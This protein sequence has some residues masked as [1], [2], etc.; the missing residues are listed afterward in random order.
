MECIE[1]QIKLYGCT[2]EELDREIN[3]EWNQ[4]MGY[5]QKAISFLN[6]AQ[7]EMTFNTEIAYHSISK[8]KYVL[9]QKL[10]DMPSLE[11]MQKL[12]QVEE[13]DKEG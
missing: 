12:N 8:A 7:A 2:T 6:D 11:R 9:L 1:T 13:P 10:N 3:T 5:M 4:R